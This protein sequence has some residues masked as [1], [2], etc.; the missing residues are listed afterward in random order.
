[1]WMP[2]IDAKGGIPISL[3]ACILT[4]ACAALLMSGNIPDSA[5]ALPIDIISVGVA[6]CSCIVFVFV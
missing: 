1:M 5:N 2:L 6:F 3:P 4:I